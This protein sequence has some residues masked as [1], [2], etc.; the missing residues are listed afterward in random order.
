MV[1]Y[2]S[3]VGTIVL[4]HD[5]RLPRHETPLPSFG[6]TGKCMHGTQGHRLFTVATLSSIF[7]ILMNVDL[8][9]ALWHHAS[10]VYRSAPNVS[11]L[12]VPFGVE[13]NKLSPFSHQT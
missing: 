11:I 6:L 4:L 1:F 9:T 7:K 8:L 12:S 3:E 10:S 5:G 13:N 2:K